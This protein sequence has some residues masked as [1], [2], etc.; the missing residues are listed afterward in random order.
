MLLG[1]NKD[2][3]SKGE[4]TG[5]IDLLKSNYYIKINKK[6]DLSPKTKT[7]KLKEFF[8]KNNLRLKNNFKNLKQNLK[9]FGSRK[10]TKSDELTDKNES[11]DDEELN[12]G[13]KSPEQYQ[14]KNFLAPNHKRMNPANELF[15]SKLTCS[16]QI[17]RSASSW[18]LG[19]GPYQTEKS[20]HMA[21]IQM[22]EQSKHFIYIENQFFIS[23]LAGPPIENL[24]A[25]ALLLRIKKAHALQEKFR[26]MVFLPLLPGFPGDIDKPSAAVLKIQLHWEY[27]TISRG[28]NSLL[29]CLK[30]EDIDP[31]E[32]IHFFSLRGH[33]IVGGVPKT[34]IIYIH[35]KVK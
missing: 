23:N 8:H 20:I 5:K 33:D 35:S 15:A 3:Q 28:G 9:N 4:S 12:Q 31:D 13:K 1:R 17:L 26:V 27:F 7:E 21:Y 32:Y 11:S 24:I 16:C 34:E 2:Y 30:R 29:E 19:L 14:M 25:D 6:Q 18:S 22:I 10:H